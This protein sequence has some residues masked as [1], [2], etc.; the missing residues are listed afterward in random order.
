MDGAAAGFASKGLGAAAGFVSKGLG[1]EGTKAV[2]PAAS[3]RRTRP[4]ILMRADDD[5]TAQQS[6]KD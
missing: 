2:T 1:V 4:N 3:K 6:L 5:P